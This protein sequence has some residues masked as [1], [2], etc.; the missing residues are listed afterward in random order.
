MQHELRRD[1]FF[2]FAG[3][4]QSGKSTI[5]DIVAHFLK[6]RGFVI[7][8]YRGGSRYSPLRSSPIAD[9]NLWL[10]CK[11]SEFVV[12]ALGREKTIH[13]IF[14]LDRGLIDR[15]MFTDT[16]LHQGKV[17]ADTA[18]ATKMFLTSPQ[19]LQNIDGIFAFV[20][21]PELALSRENK[22]KLVKKEGDVMN[23]AFLRDMRSIVEQ[24]VKWAK[25]LSPLRNKHVELIDTSE[26][27]GK[28]KEIA[29]D[30]TNFILKTILGTSIL[31]DR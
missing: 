27:D 24:D 20:T 6:G 11:T 23:A 18:Y 29:Q 19:L 15:C 9:L 30:I 1:Y 31:P 25:N 14:L 12:T 13:K 21:T 26:H 7:E 22:D 8:E 3:M 2:E 5:A 10:A 28:E 16:L 4:P 17:D